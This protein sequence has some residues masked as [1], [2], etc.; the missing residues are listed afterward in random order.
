MNFIVLVTR[1]QT[2]AALCTL[3]KTTNDANFT[4]TRHGAV[5]TSMTFVFAHERLD[6]KCDLIDFQ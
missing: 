3:Q 2:H 5:F 4:G 1:E 6:Q